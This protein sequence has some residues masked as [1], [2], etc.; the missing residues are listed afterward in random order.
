MTFQRAPPDV[1]G[2]GVSTCTPGLSRSAQVWM[3]LGLPLRTTNVVTESVTMPLCGSLVQSGETILSLTRRVMSGA[4]ENATTSAG[5]P[6][7]PAR[8]WSPEAPYED[9]NETPLPAGVAANFG[10]RS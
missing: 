5:R 7:S 4:S 8:L 2:L 1:N 9:V 10:A 6:D 3:F